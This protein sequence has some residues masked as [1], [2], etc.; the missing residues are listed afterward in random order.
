MSLDPT[1][2]AFRAAVAG[3]PDDVP[4]LRAALLIARGESPSLDVDACERRIAAIVDDVRRRLPPAADEAA[5]LAALHEVLFTELGFAGDEDAYGD[6]RNLLLDQ[7]LDRRRGIPVTLS[8]LHAEVGRQ[9]GLDL[10]I[11]GLPGH[12]VTRLGA[13]DDARYFDPYR[14]GGELTVEDCRR[15]VRS[16]YGPR[17]P[18][19]DAFLEPITPRQVIQRV[20]HNLKAGALRAGDEERAARAIEFLLA[21]FPWDLDE[22][23]DRG[24]LRE[25]LGEYARA[26]DDLEQ[27]VRYRGGARDIQTVRE[28]VRSLRRHVDEPGHP[29]DGDDEAAGELDRA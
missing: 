17:T 8:L 7:V 3:P 1:L 28:T 14:G 21:L 16:V 13:G 19:R 15:I 24:M 27:Y 26:L 5:R 25:R 18:F 11:V 20:L 23:R 9:V 12:V 2:H 22:L 4:T 29:A 6:P 10:R